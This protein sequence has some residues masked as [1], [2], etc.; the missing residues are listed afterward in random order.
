MVVAVL[1]QGLLGCGSFVMSL[2]PQK[3]IHCHTHN[4][5]PQDKAHTQLVTQGRLGCR[6]QGAGLRVQGSGCRAQGAD[7][8]RNNVRHALAR[9]GLDPG[10][11]WMGHKG[12]A[13]WEHVLS[14]CASR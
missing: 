1:H 4:V 5:D 6:A 11:A 13:A 9:H 3:A 2:K 10:T 14:V 7:G 8:L 12:A